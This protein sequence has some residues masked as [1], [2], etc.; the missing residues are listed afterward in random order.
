MR[1]LQMNALNQYK[2][3]YKGLS[4]GSHHFD[5]KVNDAFFEAFEES[6]IKGGEAN[7]YIDLTKSASM[8]AV[9]IKID[10]EVV[11][12]C[13]RCLDDLSLPVHYED[14][15]KVKF[16]DE[17]LEFDGEVLWINPADAELELGQYIYE[18]IVLSLPYQKVHGTDKKGKSLCNPDM[19]KRFS[20]ITQ[21][22]LD[23]MEEDTEPLADNP[24][25]QKLKELKDKLESK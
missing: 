4:N 19:L 17:I 7:V 6:D 25:M 16:S 23:A 15:L 10:G 8:L 9:N 20:F 5:F 13:D 18:S 12:E 11:V 22:E 3:A 1:L 14:S 21:E 24:E 2:I